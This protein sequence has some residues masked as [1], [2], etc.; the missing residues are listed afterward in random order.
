M[1]DHSTC[2]G[3]QTLT[4]ECGWKSGLVDPHSFHVCRLPGGACG[5]PNDED[6]L[7]I[8]R[9]RFGQLSVLAAGS[10]LMPGPVRAATAPD[11]TLEIAPYTLE[12]SPKHRFHTV[13]Y[14]GQIPGP[15]LRMRQGQEQTIEIRNLTGDPEVVHWHG[16]FLTSA[17]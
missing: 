7:M 10:A 2:T 9:R 16:I 5:I 12:A 6:V 14:S 15:L 11:I 3:R 17:I 13:A 4:S 8:T 1:A